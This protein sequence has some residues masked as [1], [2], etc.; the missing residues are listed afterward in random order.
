MNN[1]KLDTRHFHKD[2]PLPYSP[3]A[4]SGVLFSSI[5]ID[6]LLQS[7]RHLIQTELTIY[8]QSHSASEKLLS[9]QEARHLFH[10]AISRSTLHRWSREG[11]V[12]QHRIGSRVWYKQ[13]ELLLA[14]QS[15]KKYGRSPL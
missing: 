7:I 13:S 9:V 8:Y 1:P 15:L 14:L 4:G 6:H 11:K 2:V 3:S 12:P 5:E 10:P